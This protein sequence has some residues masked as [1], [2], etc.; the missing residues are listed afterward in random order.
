M[1][2]VMTWLWEQPGGR[3]RYTMDHVAIWADMVRRNIT[4]PHRIA[5]VTDL[6]NLP[7]GV[8]RI[9]PPRDFEDVRIPSWGPQLPQC[10]RRLA[11]FRPDASAIFGER[12]VNMDLDC[13]IGGPLDPLFDVEDGFRIY[14]GTSRTRPYNGSMM[15]LKAGARPQVFTDFSVEGATEAGNL[16]IGSDQAWITHKLGPGEPTWGDEHGVVWHGNR[17]GKNPA[18]YRVMFFPGYP[19]AW[20]VARDDHAGPWISTHYRRTKV[21]A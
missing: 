1:I 16:Y 19:K 18:D 13:V 9:K 5:C 11:M 10:L 17:M 7:K 3:E 15:L 14:R 20:H 4:M 12:F 8:V 21:A 6:P 2:T